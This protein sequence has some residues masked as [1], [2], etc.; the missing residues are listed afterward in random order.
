MARQDCRE[1]IAYA[2]VHPETRGKAKAGRQIQPCLP[3]LLAVEHEP[4]APQS[5]VCGLVNT[6]AG[7]SSE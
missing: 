6:V 4:V 1:M 7:W 2:F 3:N 5:L